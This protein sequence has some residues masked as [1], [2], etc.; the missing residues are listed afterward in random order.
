MKREYH[1]HEEVKKE[2][3]KDPKVRKAYKSELSI[4][5]K[6]TIKEAHYTFADYKKEV[7][8]DPKARVRCEKAFAKLKKKAHKNKTDRRPG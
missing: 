1:R 8:K 2:L 5:K 4:L 6:K 3:L 7:F